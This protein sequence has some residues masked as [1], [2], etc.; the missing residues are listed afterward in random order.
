MVGAADLVEINLPVDGSPRARIRVYICTYST[1]RAHPAPLPSRRRL[2]L[3]AAPTVT[4]ATTTARR[5]TIS[6]LPSYDP[7]GSHP[8]REKDRLINSAPLVINSTLVGGDHGADF[9][10]KTAAR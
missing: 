2:Q 3:F 9:G 10:N 6:L 1:P 4:P 5:H 7:V 8:V